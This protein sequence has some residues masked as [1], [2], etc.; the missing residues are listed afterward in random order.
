M[1]KINK[2]TIIILIIIFLLFFIKFNKYEFFNNYIENQDYIKRELI[3]KNKPKFKLNAY[4]INLKNKKNNMNFIYNEWKDY[5]NVTR[6]IALDSASNSHKFLLNKIYINKD[7]IKFP[8]VIMEDDVFRKY[9]FVD[10]W[11]ELLNITNTDYICFDAFFLKIKEN[12]NNVNPLFVSL[13]EHRALGFTVY[14]KTFFDKYKNINEFNS[15]FKGVID[16][17]FTHNENIIKLTPNKQVCQQ[18]VNKIST[19]RNKV[20]NTEYYNKYY[21]KAEILL[22]KHRNI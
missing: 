2:I 4:C 9:N 19:T 14:Y 18:I 1:F 15:L 22:N 6:F 3:L 7:K 8:I 12:Q 20:V 16:M 10:Y 13:K 11:N 17:N 5:L 21:K